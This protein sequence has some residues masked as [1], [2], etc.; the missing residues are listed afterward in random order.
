MKLGTTIQS[1]STSSLFRKVLI[2]GFPEREQEILRALISRV[3]PQL[4]KWVKEIHR[5]PQLGAKHGRYIP[6][7]QTVLVNPHTFLLRQR[8]G[9]GPGWISHEELMVVHEISHSVYY[10][11]PEIWKEEWLR[12]GGW[13]IGDKVGNVPRY[14]EKRPGWPPYTSEWTHKKGVVFPRRYSEKNPD[15]AFADCLAFYILGKKLQMSK[16]LS[17]FVLKVIEKIV[18]VY[19]KVLVQ[20]PEKP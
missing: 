10:N 16:Q 2:L 4:L 20:G 17:D 12:L 14:V 15:E 3:P 8:F 1:Q 11:L 13:V 7:T 6:E 9:K 18:T 5:A 19:P